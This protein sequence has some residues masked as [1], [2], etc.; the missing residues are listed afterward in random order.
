MGKNKSKFR[1]RL[2]KIVGISLFTICLILGL[3]YLPFI[4][5]IYP[6]IYVSNFYVGE[7]DTDEAKLALENQFKIP[8]E[9]IIKIEKN[10]YKIL[11]SEIDLK[12][13]FNKTVDRAFNYPNRYKLVLKPVNLTLSLN[14]DDQKLTE[15][16][17][18][19]SS[20]NGKDPVYPY[21][22][23][24]NGEI[25]IHQGVNGINLDI[26]KIKSDLLNNVAFN[27][28]EIIQAELNEINVSL[29]DNEVIAFKENLTKFIGSSIELFFEDG[30]EILNDQSIV[31]F[32][33]WDGKISKDNILK[34]VTELS[35]KINRNPQNSVFE[36]ENGLVKVFVPSKDGLVINE[37]ELVIN[38]ENALKTFQ[39][40]TTK[41]LSINVPVVVYPAKIKNE[42]VNSL[43][44]KTLL[45]RGF[46]TFKGSIPNRIHNVNLAQSKFK[47]ILVPSGE[48]VSFNQILGDVSSLTGYKQAY[49]IKDGKT[50]LGDG[51]GVC[52]VSTT[53][54]RALLNAGLPIVDRRAHAYRVGY[55][56]QGFPP[57]L[58][59]T[60]YYPTTDLKFKNDTPAHILIQPTI[61]LT[62]LSLTFEIYGTSDGRVATTSKP[63]ITSQIAPPPDL[64]VD[65]PTLPVGTVKQIEH[66]AYGAKVVFKYS[67]T[68]NGEDIINQD[69]ISN[70]RAWQA[71][72]LRGTAT[73]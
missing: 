70:Y 53:L 21:A 59:A 10:E 17:N 50:V 16:L 52:Q 28:N 20:K 64:Y 25:K 43:G 66:K 5:K 30:K 48:T 37:E 51:G 14:Y 46:S 18:I 6:N 40:G 31:T 2:F 11:S 23:I 45:G 22:T 42:D 41:T 24:A 49:V 38:I 56:E 47:G 1:S 55:Y 9:V 7:M 62:N 36:V 4:N 12:Y 57:G 26:N 3:I 33:T 54:F 67:V 32:F 73:N 8:N 35:T 72:Y 65:D 63:V 61:D 34:K 71:V 44:I 68:R 39:E 29:D 13:D 19:I 58:D 60:V 69:I 27:K 15:V